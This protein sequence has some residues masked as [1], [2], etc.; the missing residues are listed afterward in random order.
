VAGRE[1]MKVTVDPGVRVALDDIDELLFHALGMRIGGPPARRQQLVMD[2][3]PLEA[4]DA[5]ERRADAV[6]LVAARVMRIIRLL[7]LAIVLDKR[8]TRL[9]LGQGAHPILRL[10]ATNSLARI[11]AQDR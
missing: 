8:R 9:M 7:D 1:A 2:A 5:A 4:E 6:Q 10:F 11:R 3:E